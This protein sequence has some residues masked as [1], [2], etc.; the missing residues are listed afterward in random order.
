VLVTMRYNEQ[1]VRFNASCTP[2]PASPYFYS[3]SQLKSCLG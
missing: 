2:S 3:V 1:P